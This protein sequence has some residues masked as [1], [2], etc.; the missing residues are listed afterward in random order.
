MKKPVL[1]VALLFGLMA[2]TPGFSGPKNPFI[3]DKVWVIAHQGGEGLWPS[4]TMYAFERAAKMGADMLDL[5]VHMTQDGALIVIHDDSVDR[6]TNGMGK[7]RDLR[8]EQLQTLDAGWYWPQESRPTDP[9]PFRGQGIRIPTLE[10]VFRAFPQ[11]PMTIE[12]KQDQPSLAKP[13]CEMLRKYSMTDKVIIPSFIEHAMLEFRAACPEVMTAMTESEVRNL[14]FLGDLSGRS[15]QAKAL[16]VPTT[17]GP[18]QVVTPGFVSF[19]TARGL[20]VQPWT[21]NDEPEM[22]SLI[23]MGVHGINTDRPDLLM[24]VLGRAR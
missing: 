4:N 5:D 23:G 8:L 20:V 7:I 16:Q 19:A 1:L 14:I 11:M 6:T 13:F 24:K 22:R 21:I 9:H 10:E 15:P 2:C 12:I 17:A 3:T 18:I